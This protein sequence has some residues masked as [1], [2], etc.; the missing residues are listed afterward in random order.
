MEN[1]QTAVQV[2]WWLRWV[3]GLVTAICLIEAW[4]NGY[5]TMVLFQDK[6]F[7]NPAL[8]KMRREFPKIEKWVSLLKTVAL[9]GVSCA[10]IKVVYEWPVSA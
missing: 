9:I 3:F 8:E 1:V 4:I 10:G 2:F 5:R 7:N 6:P